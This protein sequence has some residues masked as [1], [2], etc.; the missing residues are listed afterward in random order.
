MAS[1]V[2]PVLIGR[3]EELRQLNEAPAAFLLHQTETHPLL[4]TIEDLHWSDAASS[5]GLPPTT[6]GSTSIIIK[7]PNNQFI[8]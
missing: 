6:P 7:P 8:S 5:V 1:F 3:S 4:L 2:T